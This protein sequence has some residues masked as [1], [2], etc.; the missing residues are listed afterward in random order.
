MSITIK[1]PVKKINQ[2]NMCDQV[3]EQLRND[4]D[5]AYTLIGLMIEVFKVNKKDIQG[6]FRDWKK[7][8]PTMYSRIGGCLRKLNEV[9]LVSTKKHGKAHYYWWNKQENFDK[10]SVGRVT[11]I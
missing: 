4:S 11:K 6:P 7:G 9:G 3:E 5:N 8:L 1:M 2:Q 10:I